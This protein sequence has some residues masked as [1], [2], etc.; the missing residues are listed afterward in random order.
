MFL[1]GQTPSRFLSHK[2]TGGGGGGA[3]IVCPFGSSLDEVI[4]LSAF[5]ASAHVAFCSLTYR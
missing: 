4:A 1:I 2:K 5:I 3:V